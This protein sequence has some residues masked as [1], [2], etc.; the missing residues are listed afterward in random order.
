VARGILERERLGLL[1]PLHVEPGPA[2]TSIFD[3]ENGQSISADMLDAGVEWTKADKSPG[4]RKNGWEKMRKMLKAAL[5]YS[6]DEPH[7]YAF[8]TC[9]H[10]FIRTVPVLPRDEKDRDDVD[11][12]AEDHVGD[13]SRYRILAPPAGK[14]GTGKRG[15]F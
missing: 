2:D 14:W 15:L 8:D 9:V 1:A 4:S 11:T 10:G 6:H 13:E 12:K 7:L 5:T 3:V